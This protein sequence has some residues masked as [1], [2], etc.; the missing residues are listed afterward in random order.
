MRDDSLPPK[1]VRC[2]NCNKRHY[3]VREETKHYRED[4]SFYVHCDCGCRYQVIK[5]YKCSIIRRLSDGHECF[6]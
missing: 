3:T 2:P 5:K 1:N 6:V 4:G